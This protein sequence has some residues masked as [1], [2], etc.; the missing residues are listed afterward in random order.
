MEPTKKQALITLGITALVAIVVSL[1]FGIL[2]I[3]FFPLLIGCSVFLIGMLLKWG[4]EWCVKN[5][6]IFKLKERTKKVKE[7]L[8]VDET[9]KKVKDSYEIVRGKNGQE[10]NQ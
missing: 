9:I 7:K 8:K 4:I 2:V 6:H 3:T 10:H 1:F 5:I